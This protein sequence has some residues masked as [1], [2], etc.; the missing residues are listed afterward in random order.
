[1][2]PLPPMPGRLAVEDFSFLQARL[3]WCY[4]GEVSPENRRKFTAER[5]IDHHIHAWWIEGGSVTLRHGPKQWTARAGEWIFNPVEPHQQEFSPKARILSINFKLEWPSGDPLV[6]QPLVV[7]AKKFA[8]LNRAALP[9]MRF[10]RHNFPGVR[11]D[12]W[13]APIDAVSYFELNRLFSRW[14]AAYLR[15]AFASGIVPSRMSEIDPRVQAALRELDRQP[16]TQP[17]RE[18]SLAR[19]IGLSAGHL[20]RLFVEQLRMTPRA[21]LQKRRYSSAVALLSDRDV[22]V[23]KIGYDLGFSSPGHF[24]HWFR[25]VSGKSPRQYRMSRQTPVSKRTKSR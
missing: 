18:K 5:D 1:M 13:R 6:D 15:V 25:E 4:E 7:R 22:P 19:Q 14:L 11:N 2:T 24:S 10:I 16:W 20:D 3:L 21:Y 8:G 17:F 23:K 9:L 12:L